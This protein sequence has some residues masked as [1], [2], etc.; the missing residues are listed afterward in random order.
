MESAKLNSFFFVGKDP[1]ENPHIGDIWGS[2]APV[3][4]SRRKCEYC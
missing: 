2:G 3:N 1:P 4:S